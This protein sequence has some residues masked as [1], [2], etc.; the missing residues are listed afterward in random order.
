[1]QFYQVAKKVVM[2]SG[3][4]LALIP[5]TGWPARWTVTDSDLAVL[6][7]GVPREDSNV[8]QRSRLGR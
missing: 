1:M 8:R 3:D 6:G 7:E 4:V 2:A 5:G